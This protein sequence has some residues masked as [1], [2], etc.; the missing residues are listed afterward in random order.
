MRN[1][2]C[3]KIFYFLCGLFFL[4]L[5]AFL[6]SNFSGDTSFN[7]CQLRYQQTEAKVFD[8]ADQGFIKAWLQ[9]EVLSLHFSC[10]TKEE[11]PLTCSVE[12][13]DNYYLSQGSKKKGGWCELKPDQ[14]L[15][16]LGRSR[17]MQ[18]NMELGLPREATRQA[19]VAEGSLIFY[20]QRE[21]YSTIKITIVNSK[22]QEK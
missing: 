13:F 4:G 17:A 2:L 1:N 12:G 8:L 18:V 3:K 16:R 21:R 11:L 7:I 6:R 20:Y 9:P 10:S 14:V 22:Y 5:L 15:T 19:V